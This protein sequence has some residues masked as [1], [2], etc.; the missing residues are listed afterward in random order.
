MLSELLA[1]LFFRGDRAR[2]PIRSLWSGSADAPQRDE[3]EQD[4]DR[5][6]GGLPAAGEPVEPARDTEYLER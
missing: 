3:Q 2:P 6:W 4:L 1:S 5:S